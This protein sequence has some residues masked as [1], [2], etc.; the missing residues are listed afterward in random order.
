MLKN[1]RW[2]R[3]K[4]NVK[5]IGIKAPII[6]RKSQTSQITNLTNS[7]P[8][9]PTENFNPAISDLTFQVWSEAVVTETRRCP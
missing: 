9:P 4:H 1:V 3:I 8:A 7:P 5:N 2:E 6:N